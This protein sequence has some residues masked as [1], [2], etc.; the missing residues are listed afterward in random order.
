MYL[1]IDLGTSALKVILIDDDQ[2]LLG[3]KNIPLEVNCPQ[4]LFSEQSPEEWW[5]AL[6]QAVCSLKSETDL[7]RHW[8]LGSDDAWCCAPRQ[9]RRAPEA[10]HFVERRKIR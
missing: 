5:N 7:S 6:E 1:G 4:T 2:K 10:S 8:A 9:K 3:E